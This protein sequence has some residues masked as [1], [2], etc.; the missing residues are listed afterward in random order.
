MLQIKITRINHAPH[1]TCTEVLEQQCA[2]IVPAYRLCVQGLLLSE[3]VTRC[4]QPHGDAVVFASEGCCVSLL[5]RRSTNRGPDYPG[6]LQEVPPTLIAVLISEDAPRT[7][8]RLVC[9]YKACCTVSLLPA[10]TSPTVMQ[11][12]SHPKAAV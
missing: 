11:F 7:S 3:S 10:V 8:L 5:A 1:G 12:F 4:D 6:L 9:V 2:Q